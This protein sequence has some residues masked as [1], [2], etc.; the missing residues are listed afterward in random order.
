M[1]KTVK[2]MYTE[3]LKVFVRSRNEKN[4]LT[5]GGIVWYTMVEGETIP[6]GWWKIRHRMT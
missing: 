2:A 4:Y 1:A 6:A 3:P 5:N